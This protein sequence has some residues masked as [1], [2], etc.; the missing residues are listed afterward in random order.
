[1]SALSGSMP[2]GLG[3]FAPALPES[4]GLCVLRVAMDVRVG[5]R[6]QMLLLVIAERHVMG[7]FLG[8]KAQIL[9]DAEK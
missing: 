3:S 8:P 1:M 6:R 4:F 2:S 5:L 7:H 9:N